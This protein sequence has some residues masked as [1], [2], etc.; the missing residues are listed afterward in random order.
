MPQLSVIDL[1]MFLLETPA[2]PFNIGPLVLLRPPKG[3]RRFADRLLERMLKQEAGPPFNHRL[4]LSLTRMPS[5]EPM[6]GADLAAHVHRITLGGG[7]SMDELIA[8]VCELHEAL[9]PREGLLWQFL[10]L[11]H[12]SE[13]T[14]PY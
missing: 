12:I 2:R 11:I 4:Q 6:A 13:P 9:L 8:K 7:G 14:R 5:V 3:A 1:A 10:S